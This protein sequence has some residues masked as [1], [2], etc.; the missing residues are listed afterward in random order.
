MRRV[1]PTGDISYA[2]NMSNP[3]D[4]V[5]PMGPILSSAESMRLAQLIE[6]TPSIP[7][8]NDVDIDVM[9]VI[10]W[11]NIHEGDLRVNLRVDGGLS[12]IPVCYDCAARVH[13]AIA[14]HDAE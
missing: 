9:C 11:Q 14:R 6:E 5:S 1:Y 12:P 4:A 7:T 13:R 3:N 2:E 10:C 8:Q